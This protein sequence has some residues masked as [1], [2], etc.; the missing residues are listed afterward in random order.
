LE[1]CKKPPFGPIYSLTLT[2]LEALRIYI[3]ENLANGFI[4]HSKCPTSG[5]ILFVSKKDGSLK[6]V[7]DFRGLNKITIPKKYPLP[8]VSKLLDHLGGA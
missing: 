6:L 2:E 7:V 5:T 8:L 4:R 3:N 1:E